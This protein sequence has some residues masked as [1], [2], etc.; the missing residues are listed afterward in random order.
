MSKNIDV[1]HDGW[2]SRDA[3]YLRKEPYTKKI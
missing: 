3:G 2:A 1:D